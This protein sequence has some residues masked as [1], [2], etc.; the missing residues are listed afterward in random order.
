MKNIKHIAIVLAV[1][2]LGV[3]AFSKKDSSIVTE[4]S[5]LPSNSGINFCY[6]WNTEAGDSASLKMNLSG[7][8]GS[9]VS[10]QFD[11]MPYEKDSKTGKFTGMAGAVDP[12][13]M[14]RT[15]NV[16]WTAMGEGI[17]NQ[18]QLYIDFGEGMAYPAF[19]EMTINSNGVYTYKD[20]N[21][22]TYP[23]AMQE[24]ECSDGAVLY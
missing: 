10:G 5:Q 21:N 1:I 17:V 8:G 9:I 15:A 11:Y 12:Y 14:A 6:I 7:D 13:K 18:E 23:I 22:L 24:T 2:A 16:I 4:E 19:G 20:L 3:F